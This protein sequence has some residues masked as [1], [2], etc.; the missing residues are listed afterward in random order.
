M[1]SIG[2]VRSSAWTWLFSFDAENECLSGGSRYRPT[3]RRSF[4]TKKGSEEIL[5]LRILRDC[6]AKS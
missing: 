1:G 5:K 6:R 4:S 3:V 2:W